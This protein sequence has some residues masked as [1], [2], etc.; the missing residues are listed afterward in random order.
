MRA[1]IG[2]GGFLLR[3]RA[4]RT[5]LRKVQ[6]APGDGSRVC[7]GWSVWGWNELARQ[8]RGSITAVNS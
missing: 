1:S 7:G 2:L 5:E 6:G 8:R 3:Q 4:L